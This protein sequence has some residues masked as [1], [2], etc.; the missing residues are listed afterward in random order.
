MASFAE[1]STRANESEREKDRLPVTE[2]ELAGLTGPDALRLLENAC[3]D[4][5]ESVVEGGLRALLASA[6][7]SPEAEAALLR[8]LTKAGSGGRVREMLLAGGRNGSGAPP[9]GGYDARR[10]R[11]LAAN[12]DLARC[13]LHS[14]ESG[15]HRSVQAFRS[16]RLRANPSFAALFDVIRNDPDLPQTLKAMLAR[17]SEFIAQGGEPRSLEPF[18]EDIR[19]MTGL[20]AGLAADPALTALCE[21]A[22]DR[23]VGPRDGGALEPP[24]NGNSLRSRTGGGGGA[25]RRELLQRAFRQLLLQNEVGSGQFERPRAVS[26]LRHGATPPA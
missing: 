6:A 22:L 14:L 3:A 11:F 23:T 7:E 10:F 17:R 15:M 25:A 8:V 5:E 13:R 16:A 21:V 19:R 24:A 4:R 18:W 9:E 26:Q 2:E 1:K 20:L 12:P